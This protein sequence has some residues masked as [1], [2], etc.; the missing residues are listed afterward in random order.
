MSNGTKA[1]KL[2]RTTIGV[3]FCVMALKFLAWWLTGSVALYSDALESIVNVIAAFTAWAAIRYAAK[4]AD[5]GHPFGHYKAEYFSAVLEGVLIVIAALL[6][7]NE[8]VRHLM[9]PQKIDQPAA[10][11][12]I[13]IVAAVINAIWAW[14]LVRT[15]RMERSPALVADGKHIMTDVW[16]S[17][18]VV[19]GLILAFATGWLRLDPILAIVV[20][21]NIVWQGWKVISSSVDGLMDRAV[22]PDQAE[23]IHK[24]ILA[25]AGGAIEAHDIKTRMAGPATFIEF[26]LVVDGSMTVEKSHRMCD[27]LET[28]LKR[29]IPGARITIHVEPEYKAK[30]DGIQID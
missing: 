27:R 4:P 24:T 26:H 6:I 5:H 29:E 20:A 23:L 9:V 22:E 13:N 18:G 7:L 8:A 1:Q 3:A 10:G 11:L 28:A 30:E 2:A 25:N 19:A 21:L 12:G 14:L 16:T 17:V 15:G